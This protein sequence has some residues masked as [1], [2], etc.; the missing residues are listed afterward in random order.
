MWPTRLGN[1]LDPSIRYGQVPANTLEQK[2]DESLQHG[3][4]YLV[5]LTVRSAEGLNDYSAWGVFTP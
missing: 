3:Q 2:P 5:R 4:P 1:R